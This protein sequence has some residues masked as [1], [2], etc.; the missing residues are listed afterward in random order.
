MT[1][2]GIVL[3]D[4]VVGDDLVFLD[5]PD[6]FG[7]LGFF[8]GHMKDSSGLDFLSFNGNFFGEKVSGDLFFRFDR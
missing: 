4:F 1:L 7:I 2:R 8:K 6:E 3:G 5:F